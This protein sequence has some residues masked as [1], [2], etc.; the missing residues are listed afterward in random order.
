[1]KDYDLEKIKSDKKHIEQ[2][3]NNAT[4]NSLENLQREVAD[5]DTLASDLFTNHEFHQMSLE[6]ESVR[7]HSLFTLKQQALLRLK[8]L[9]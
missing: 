9:E 1:M 2:E 6:D 5:R 7:V 8:Q 3:I 4:K